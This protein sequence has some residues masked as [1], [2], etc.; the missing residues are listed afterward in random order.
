MSAAR[1]PVIEPP[2]TGGLSELLV[3]SP[4][5]GDGD[6]EGGGEGKPSSGAKHIGD[7]ARWSIAVASSMAI[8]TQAKLRLPRACQISR[9]DG[10]STTSSGGSSV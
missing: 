5:S 1:V 2:S 4:R 8:V 6:G 7:G 3:S 9:S 10:W